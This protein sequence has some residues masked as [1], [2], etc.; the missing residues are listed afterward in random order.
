VGSMSGNFANISGERCLI[1]DD[2]ITSGKTLHEVVKYVKRHGSVPVG[3]VVIFDKRG[4]R[5]IEGV[6]VHS[7]FKISRID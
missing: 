7:L 2:V 3:I 6:P 4:I 5:E 1:V